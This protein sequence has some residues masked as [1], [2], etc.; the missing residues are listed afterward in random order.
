M[1]L[2]LFIFPFLLVNT[3]QK[4]DETRIIEYNGKKVKVIY[5]ID[6]R[7]YGL[8]KGKKSGFLELNKDGSGQYKYDI[9][10]FALP[11]CKPG[12]I[13]LIWG[14][15]LDDDGEPVKFERE[16]GFSYPIL[17]QTTSEKSFQGCRKN[18]LLD[19]IIEKKD[20]SLGISSSDDWQKQE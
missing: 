9:F 12:P 14:M 15:L 5:Q 11:G 13:P 18:V 10:G 3:S 2:L 1:K 20:G 19:F 17:Y 7:F 8:Y 6:E 16:Y 4:N